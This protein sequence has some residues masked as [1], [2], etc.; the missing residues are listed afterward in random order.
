MGF[1]I[2][3]KFEIDF[4]RIVEIEIYAWMILDL[5]VLNEWWQMKET[6]NGFASEDAL[7][8]FEKTW[9]LHTIL[10]FVAGGRGV[11]DVTI[12]EASARTCRSVGSS[13]VV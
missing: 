6:Y 12:L 7:T 2:F 11:T 3:S 5:N 8:Q 10:K 9:R 13:F 1:E 4:E